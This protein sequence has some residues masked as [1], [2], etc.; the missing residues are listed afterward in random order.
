MPTPMLAYNP[1]TVRLG[2]V[3]SAILVALGYLLYHLHM[4]RIRKARVSASSGGAAR[5]TSVSQLFEHSVRPGSAVWT[6]V[7]RAALILLAICV[8]AG[9]FLILLPEGALDHLAQNLRLR[10]GGALPQES[11]S[12]LYLGDETKGKEFHI[13]GVVRNISTQPIEKLDAT[14]RLYA[15]DGSLLETTV[16]RMD[17][18]VIAPDATSSFNLTYPDYAGQFGSYAVDFKLRQGDPLPYKD[19][20]HSS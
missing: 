12:L 10:N 8:A 15:L 13:R 19:M 9:F 11:I 16:V 20:R 5:P 18:E 6:E 3:L 14:V 2:L 1:L 7:M 4:R 17:I